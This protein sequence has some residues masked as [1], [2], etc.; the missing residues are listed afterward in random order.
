M[1]TL[2]SCRILAVVATF[3]GFAPAVFAGP[4]LICHPLVVDSVSPLLP[5]AAGS[6]WRLPHPDY[7][8]ASLTTDTLALLSVDA[9]ILSPEWRICAARRSTRDQDPA[10]AEALLGSRSGPH[11]T[12]AGR[13]PMGQGS[14]G[15]TPVTF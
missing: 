4:P 3:I 8:V 14:R 11:R 7:D 10:A 15:S 1:R 9:P 12:T 6:E 5:W 2:R 13:S